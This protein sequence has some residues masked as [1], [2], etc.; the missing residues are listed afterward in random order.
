ML[1]RRLEDAAHHGGA[2]S[3]NDA[4][5]LIANAADWDRGSCE[6]VSVQVTRESETIEDGY[7]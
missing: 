5:M 6:T 2:L 7:R 3:I 4:R 1:L